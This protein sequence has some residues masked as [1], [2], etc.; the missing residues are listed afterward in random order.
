MKW[1][2]VL[3]DDHCGVCSSMRRWLERQP[4]FVPLK[5][6]AL[7]S[8]DLSIRFP[9]IAAFDPDEKLV[10]VA[11]DG[12]VWRGDG[13]WIMLLWALKSGRGISEKL[14][15]PLLRPLAR[16]IVTAVSSNRLSLSN[17]LGLIPDQMAGDGKCS[18]G[19]CSVR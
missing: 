6:V 5:M 15:S 16:K 3:Y 2:A 4:S 1:L 19:S 12:L 13:A 17:W 11:D 14:S 18:N 8:T 9:G 7:H 10:L